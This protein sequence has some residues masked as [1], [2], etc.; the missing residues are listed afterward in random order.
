[1]EGL[2]EHYG[3]LVAQREPALPARAKFS[4]ASTRDEGRGGSSM[5][6]LAWYALYPLGGA[7]RVPGLSCSLWVP[8]ARRHVHTM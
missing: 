6:A 2:E 4:T 5:G 1:M 7:P 8:C 3:D